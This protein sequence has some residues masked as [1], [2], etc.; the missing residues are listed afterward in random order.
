MEPKRILC[1]TRGG[2]TQGWGNVFR[3]ASFA[4]F[5]RARG[6]AEV[7]FFAEGPDEVVRF[8]ESRGF[9]VVHLGEGVTLEEE[10][11]ALA[12]H[13]RVDL[14]MVEM[15]DVTP[16]RQR[17]LREHTDRLVVFDDLCD[18]VYDADL[19]VCGQALPS[20]ANRHLS[21]AGTKFLVGYD[22]FLMRPE[23][24]AYGECKREHSAGLER[25]LVTLGGGCY[26][27]G[28]RKAALALA[29]FESERGRGVEATFVLGY[30]D[31]EEL[32]AAIRAVLPRADIL[33]GVSDLDRL[34]WEHDLVIASA[35]YTKLEAAIL[36]T[37]QIVMS[38]QWHQIPLA[39][40]FA[41][42]TGVPDVGYMAY[43]QPSR[44]AA[45]LR[46]LEPR[47][48]RA[49][50]AWSARR[51]VDGRGYERVYAAAFGAGEVGSRCTVPAA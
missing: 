50:L 11:A 7:T 26:D 19:V 28:Y 14:V 3:L 25:V 40:T 17:L 38:V 4:E 22:Y 47:D 33:G 32:R 31:R 16:G 48:V 21:A 43:V 36:R 44:L 27:V 6:R 35:G 8:L 24:R 46:A 29:E 18:H 10:R 1:R 9:P 2:R 20:H 41:S 34:L 39:S 15:L 5:C 49:E 30:D 13:D 37:P 12:A 23:F 45:E 42:C 51:V